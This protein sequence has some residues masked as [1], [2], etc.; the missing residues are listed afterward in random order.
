VSTPT[1]VGVRFV[2]L[3]PTAVPRYTTAETFVGELLLVGD[4]RALTGLYF[5]PY[6]RA[7]TGIG[8]AWR[9]DRAL[10]AGALEQ[11][12]AYL[13]GELT[14]FD[15]AVATGGGAFQQQV[16]RALAEIPYGQTTSYGRLAASIGRP[17]A[18]RAVGMANGRNP[19]R[20]CCRAI[21]SSA[22]PAR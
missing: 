7:L 8:A 22:P 2:D 19:S 9:P 17:T 10:L 15:L 4:G 18:S 16:G 5:H 3:D 13:A 11:V 21:A 14:V 12:R 6:D 20:W 1:A